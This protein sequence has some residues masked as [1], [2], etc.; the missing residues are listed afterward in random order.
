MTAV[1]ARRMLLPL[2]LVAGVYAAAHAQAVAPAPSGAT[3]AWTLK[4]KGA[5]RWQQV[6]P[7]GAL[8]VSTDTALAA[9]DIERGQVAWEKPELGGLP[10]D[11]VQMIEGSLLMEA[12]RPGLLLV[13]DP[14][15]GTVVFDSRRLNLAQVIT[16]RVLPPSGTLLVH[17]RRSAKP[18]VVAL[19]DL[20]T[21]AQRWANESLFQQSEPRRRGLAGLM[22]GMVPAAAEATALPVLQA[23]AG[24]ARR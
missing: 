6:T 15:T 8:L 2:S 4:M 19:Y 22:Q 9:V 7:A 3:P 24:A 12:A 21:G 18:P 13:F 5:I 14:V 1:S 11:S 23:G 17:G 16:R 10:A 20:S